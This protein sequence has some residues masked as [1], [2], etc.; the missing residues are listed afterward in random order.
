[1]GLGCGMGLK[2][3]YLRLLADQTSPQGPACGARA[4]A[5][6]TGAVGDQLPT[7]SQVWTQQEL[8]WASLFP[9]PLVRESRLLFSVSVPFGGSRYYVSLAPRANGR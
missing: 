6:P 5:A 3:P 8:C 7:G 2:W 9:S 4:F 1:M